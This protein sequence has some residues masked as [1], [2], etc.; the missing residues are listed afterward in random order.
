LLHMSRSSSKGA[1]SPG[2]I[3]SI[4]LRSY[5]ANCIYCLGK[6]QSRTR[7]A[8]RSHSA[9]TAAVTHCCVPLSH[10]RKR[11]RVDNNDPDNAMHV[12]VDGAN[13]NAPVR[14]GVELETTV[15]VTHT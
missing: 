10:A 5:S 1:Q 3:S 8:S 2:M 4:P 9:P 11:Q 6:I 13:T 14:R 12:T 15:P 7:R